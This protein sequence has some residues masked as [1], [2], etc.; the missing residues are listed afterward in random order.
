MARSSKDRAIAHVS[1][2]C[3]RCRVRS[4]ADA[5]SVK[6]PASERVVLASLR[7]VCHTEKRP[8]LGDEYPQL[9]TELLPVTPG[10]R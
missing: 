4:D 2:T 6:P 1:Y 3:L 10:S 8:D 5:H 7:V 9:V